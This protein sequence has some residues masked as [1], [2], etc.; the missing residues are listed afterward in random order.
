[1]ISFHEATKISSIPF[2]FPYGQTCD[3]LLFMHWIMTP[4]VVPQWV[5][6]WEWVVLF[7]FIQTFILWSLNLIAVEIQNPFGLDDNDI[8]GR[9]AQIELNRSLMMLVEPESWRT[10]GL[11]E[12]AEIYDALSKNKKV[13]DSRMKRMQS[14]AEIWGCKSAAV[15]GEDAEVSTATFSMLAG[16]AE[17][18]STLRRSVTTPLGMALWSSHQWELE[19]QEG[20]SSAAS[21]STASKRVRVEAPHRAPARQSVVVS[22]PSQGPTSPDNSSASS[23]DHEPVQVSVTGSSPERA[24]SFEADE[25]SLQ[26]GAVDSVIQ[27]E[28]QESPPPWSNH[29]AQKIRSAGY[30]ASRNDSSKSPSS[31]EPEHSEGSSHSRV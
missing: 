7:T 23:D 8:D 25:D 1:M 27:V 31:S 19:N 15:G 16:A 28:I 17:K 13:K 14:F 26:T 3:C 22:S 29:A 2:P 24:C 18:A 30:R 10:P 6:S 5:E 21:S 12:N 11:G 4:L 20:R 9:Q